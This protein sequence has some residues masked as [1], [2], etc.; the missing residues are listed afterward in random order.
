MSEHPNPSKDIRAMPAY[1]IADVAHYLHVPPAT[2][3]Y[4]SVGQKHH[5]PLIAIP[6]KPRTAL[7]SFYN[8]AELHILATIRRHHKIA[9]ASV[10]SALDHL[11]LDRDAQSPMEREHPLISDSFSTDGKDLFVEKYGDLINVSRRGQV[12]MRETIEGALQRIAY[13]EDSKPVTVYPF[14]SSSR[15]DSPRIIIVNP[16]ISSGHPIIEGTG[17]TTHVIAERYKAGESIKDLM[18]DYNCKT[19]QIEEAIRCEFPVAA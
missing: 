12:A 1:T 4:W 13:G 15:Q 10:R 9:M 18:R 3:R 11:L 2:I 16:Y 14:T 5:K 17:I 6:K 7:L 19:E 8:F